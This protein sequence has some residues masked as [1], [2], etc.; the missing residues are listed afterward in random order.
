LQLTFLIG[1]A[2]GIAKPSLIEPAI[3]QTV[4]AEPNDVMSFV[5][6]LLVK[7]F[8]KAWQSLWEDIYDVAH[9]SSININSALEAFK[10][11]YGCVSKEE[12]GRPVSTGIFMGNR[13]GLLSALTT[14]SGLVIEKK[15][16]SD[17]SAGLRHL[18]GLIDGK[19]SAFV[20]GPDGTVEGAYLL[21]EPRAEGGSGKTTCDFSSHCDSLR[22]VPGFGLIGLGMFKTA[23]LFYGGSLQVEVYFSGK[24]GDWTYRSTEAIR[25]RIGP[26]VASKGIDEEAAEKVLN[27]AISMS[28]HRKGGTIIVGDHESVLRQSEAPRYRLG[29][30]R[31]QDL[32][33]AQENHLYNLA[34]QEFALV[35]KGSGELCAS[36]VRMLAKVPEGVKI[37]VTPS[38]GGRHRSAAEI[39][40]CAGCIAFVVSDDGPLSI[41]ADGKRLVRL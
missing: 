22:N 20:V 11:V 2:L 14:P 38:D 33:G 4:S 10:L 37:D 34:T 9:L 39:T 18:F 7:N 31:V 21:P 40:A 27:V 32:V 3:G 8:P 13:E 19:V 1:H 26:A 28:N 41:F 23:K 17:S 25:S 12:E 29:G 16:I 30:I 15:P 6:T 24:I 36:S 5:K 35:V